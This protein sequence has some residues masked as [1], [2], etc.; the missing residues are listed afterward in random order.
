VYGRL[1]LAIARAHW[2]LRAGAVSLS[3]PRVYL[4]WGA[5]VDIASGAVVD[6]GDDVVFRRGATL[7]VRG[8]LTVGSGTF[9]N[10]HLHLACIDTV[11]IGREVRFG[12]RVS[13]HDENHRFEPVGRHER[14]DLVGSP[15][16]VADRS[17]IGAGC[18]IL[19][20]AHIG[21]DSVVAAGSVVT[22]VIPA[23]V[24]AAGVPARV[25]RPLARGD[26]LRQ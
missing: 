24:L 15:V 25:I 16:T 6:I 1:G 26:G 18:I 4:G 2:S 5:R 19:A 20:G 23:G 17:W 12:E 8:T 3:P 11:S 22:G 13:I 14:G 10:E 21:P 7:V 9:F